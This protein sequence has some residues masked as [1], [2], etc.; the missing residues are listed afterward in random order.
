LQS[1]YLIPPGFKDNVS[2]DA[3]IEHEYKNNI[4][5]YFRSNGFDLVNLLEMKKLKVNFL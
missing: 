5:N 2:F 4:I 3:Y 1:E